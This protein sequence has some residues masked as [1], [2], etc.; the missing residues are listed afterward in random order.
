MNKGVLEK[1]LT[2]FYTVSGMETSLLDANF[3]TVAMTKSKSLNFCSLIHR[4]EGASNICKASDIQHLTKAKETLLPAVYTCP[5][6]ITEAII[7]IIRGEE[8]IA[9]IISTMGINADKSTDAEIISSAESFSKKFSRTK[10]SSSVITLNHLS[11]AELDSYL[12]MLRLLSEH[13]SNDESLFFSNESIGKLVKSYVKNNLSAKLTLN[14]IS[15]NLH[16]STVT[17]TE[18]FKNEFGITIMEYVTK[19]RM[20]LSEKLLITTD[21]PLREVSSLSGFADVEYFSRT[22]KRFH[23]ASPAAWRKQERSQDTQ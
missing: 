22:F 19:K 12:T 15:R 13:I 18:H 20:Q 21:L 14:D 1:L 9:Y 8:I 10:L 11:E 23:G 3:H 6:G 2:D 7:P 5:Y 16:C 17:L 4:A